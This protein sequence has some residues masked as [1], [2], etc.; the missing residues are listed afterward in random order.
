MKSWCAEEYVS[1]CPECDE[2]FLDEPPYDGSKDDV[3]CP[4][5]D[6][7]LDLEVGVNFSEIPLVDGEWKYPEDIA[8]YDLDL[9]ELEEEDEN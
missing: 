8:N 6:A 5:C 3:I 4:Y 7:K 1:R 2:Y 9:E